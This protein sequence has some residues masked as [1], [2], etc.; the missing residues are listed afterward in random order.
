V[1]VNTGTGITVGGTVINVNEAKNFT[2][3]R[4]VA[5]VGVTGATN[6]TATGTA[7]SSWRFTNHSGALSGEANDVDPAGDPGYLVWDDSASLITV[8]GNVYSDEGV[9]VST[10]CDGVTNNV[11]LR[12]A[13]LTTYSTTCNATT[14][15]Y[16]IPNVAYNSLDSLVLYRDTFTNFFYQ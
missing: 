12:V 10:H 7:V 8:S 15:A 14:G 9:T 3:N 6:V 5:D 1:Q 13:G 11:V 4:F 16:S 2:N